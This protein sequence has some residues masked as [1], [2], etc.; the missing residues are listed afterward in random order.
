MTNGSFMR[1]TDDSTLDERKTLM[2]HYAAVA[3]ILSASSLGGCVP[4]VVGAGATAGVVAAQDRGFEQAV[5]DNEI[6]FEINRKLIARDSKLFSRVSTQVSKGRVVLNGFVANPE[7]RITAMK[8]AWSVSGVREVLDE[9]Q[10]GKPLSFSERTSDAL[11]TTKLR[12]RLTGDN[13]ISSI[14]YSIETLRGTVYLMGIAQDSAELNRVIAHAR[15]VSGVRNVVSNVEI[16]TARP[17]PAP[18]SAPAGASRTPAPDTVPAPSRSG[19][20]SGGT[21]GGGS[22]DLYVE[23][24]PAP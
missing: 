16:K 8:I 10:V 22:S 7:D 4:L 11:I 23:P 20:A 21:S 24:L 1:C 17:A 19:G 12:A 6:A 13:S 15:D 2:R 3:L 5:D 18:A 14:N 9:L